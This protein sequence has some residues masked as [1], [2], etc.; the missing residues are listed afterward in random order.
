MCPACA[1]AARCAHAP[2]LTPAAA[3]SSQY[4]A[5]GIMIG[6]VWLQI[7][8]QADD[9]QDIVNVLFFIAAFK[10][11]MSISVLPAYLEDKLIFIRDRANGTYG[12]AAYNVANAIVSLPFLFLL[13]LICSSITYWLI[14][15]NSDVNAFF[16]FVWNLFISFACAEALMFVVASIVPFFVVGIA[17]GAFIYGTFS[18]C[19]PLA[20]LPR[21]HDEAWYPRKEGKA[22]APRRL[23]GPDAGADLADRSR[24]RARL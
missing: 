11:F 14:G 21:A 23:V 18:A 4:I 13:S 15:L 16:F 7:G 22:S 8:T 5:L 2:V 19:A 9:I 10:V 24:A 6:T 20:A 12:V 1:L 3:R 17:V